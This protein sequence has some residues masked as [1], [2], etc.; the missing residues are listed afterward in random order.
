MYMGLDARKLCTTK[1]QTSQCICSLI[2]AFVILIL[3]ILTTPLGRHKIS[4]EQTLEL[5]LVENSKDQLSHVEAHMA[6]TTNLISELSLCCFIKN[7]QV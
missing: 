6:K 1:V 5:Y 2:S 3:E 4:K 7:L